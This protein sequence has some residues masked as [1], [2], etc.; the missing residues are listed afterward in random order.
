MLP[1]VCVLSLFRM[2]MPLLSA[3]L[4]RNLPHAEEDLRRSS[5]SVVPRCT[6]MCV[7]VDRMHVQLPAPQFF[8]R[9][10]SAF[11]S[12]DPFWL[13]CLPSPC[14][15]QDGVPHFCFPSSVRLLHTH[16]RTHRRGLWW[17]SWLPTIATP[18]RSTTKWPASFS[19][20]QTPPSAR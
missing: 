18:T 9:S 1:R 11:R 12:F 14:A 8:F 7:S 19:A 3:F 6:M 13:V 16:V 15:R 20:T 2:C 4:F 10:C 5:T 17:T